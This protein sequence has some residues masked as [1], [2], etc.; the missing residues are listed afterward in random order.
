[1]SFLVEAGLLLSEAVLTGAIVGV[2]GYVLVGKPLR[3]F[4]ARLPP[5]GQLAVFVLVGVATML[6]GLAD[7]AGFLAKLLGVSVESAWAILIPGLFSS[8]TL[9]LVVII[10]AQGVS[11]LQD[12]V[13]GALTPFVAFVVGMNLGSS[14]ALDGLQDHWLAPEFRMEITL[15]VLFFSL[16]AGVIS[17]ATSSAVQRLMG[18]T[19]ALLRR[20]R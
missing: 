16:Y 4:L 17:G 11:A 12:Y 18:V 19:V 15:L 20:D 2:V 6:A 1:M 10:I 3:G 13:L 9:I 8:A 7:F 5:L 14:R